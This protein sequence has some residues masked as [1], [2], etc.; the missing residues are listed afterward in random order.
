MKAEA[1]VNEKRASPSVTVEGEE[2]PSR[3]EKLKD[4]EADVQVVSGVG[5]P[6]DGG[7]GW[8]IVICVFFA[9]GMLGCFLSF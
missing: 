7:Y 2:V 6:P 9:N 5:E 1:S 3:V 4:T 8:V